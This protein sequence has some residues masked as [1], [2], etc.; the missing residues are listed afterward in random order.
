LRAQ[1]NN[2]TGTEKTMELMMMSSV[3]RSETFPPHD[4]WLAGYANSYYYVGYVLSAMLS[5]LGG[6]ASTAGFNM[7]ISL[8]FAL[9]GLTAFGVVANL[10]RSR[11]GDG[12]SLT[13]PAIFTGLLGAFLVIFFSNLQP[14]V[15]EI[16]YQAQ[17]VSEDYLRFWDAKNRDR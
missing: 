14:V 11:A 10:V 6:I 16:P 1:Q 9:T 7:T 12:R 2:L 8:L 5:M 4:A 15:V 13:R 3:M 17:A